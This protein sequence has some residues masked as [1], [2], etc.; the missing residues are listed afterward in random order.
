MEIEWL[1]RNCVVNYAI[2]DRKKIA[3]IQVE[4]SGFE[5]LAIPSSMS[6]FLQLLLNNLLSSRIDG[7][8]ERTVQNIHFLLDAGGGIR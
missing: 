2:D 5:P 3:E 7:R 1:V 4:N 8:F 6:S